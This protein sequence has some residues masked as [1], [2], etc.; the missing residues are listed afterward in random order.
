LKFAAEPHARRGP[1]SSLLAASTFGLLTL[2][3]AALTFATDIEGVLPGALDQPQVNA[4][5]RRSPT[6][7]PL[8]TGST[9]DAADF[10]VGAFLDTGA[11]GHLLSNETAGYH[12][13]N[14]PSNDVDGLGVQRDASV[15]GQRT[16]F[17]DVGGGGTVQFN[18]SEPLYMQLASY[19]QNTVYGDPN[20]PP[21]TFRPQLSDFG[22]VSG[23]VR[24]QVGPVVRPADFDPLQNLDVIG[25]PAMLGKVTVM[26]N[27]GLN[28]F[29]TTQD[30][31]HDT[32]VLDT[33]IYNPGTPFNPVDAAV[34]QASVNPGIPG[35]NRHIGL[36]YANFN[37]FSTVTPTGAP[38]PT[39]AHNPFV[40]KDP[41]RLADGTSQPD[42]PGIKMSF[43]GATAEGNFLLDTGAGASFI[44]KG[45]AASLGIH[46][47]AGHEPGDPQSDPPADPI[48]VD[49][50]NNPIPNQFTIDI[51]AFGADDPN[52]PND[53]SAIRIAGFYL[54]NML[55][56]TKEGSAANDA[57][58]RHFNYRGAP[59]LVNDITVSRDLGGGNL[60]TIT[61]DGVFGMNFLA[62]SAEPITS[63]FDPFVTAP[64]AF[65][66]ITF[67]EPNA[68][69]GIS[70]GKPGD[71]D[72]DGDVDG[73]DVGIWASNFTGSGG[74]T[75]KTW[76]QGD[77]DY[78][79]DVDGNDVGLWATNFT[80]SGG[81]ILSLPDADP[82]AVAALEA[83]GF[84]VVPEPT[85]LALLAFG[86]LALGRRRRQAPRA[87]LSRLNVV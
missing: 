41:V 61:L 8:T 56:R 70:M 50:N 69:L 2:A 18:V 12:D 29:A 83:M 20:D 74:S 63:I 1:S 62:A 55:V 17:E 9:T 84:T 81:R 22:P 31:E 6:G 40:G 78:D 52:D 38:G 7:D 11:S 4:L 30:V 51:S 15:G 53:S 16:V 25:M 49:A 26:D 36:S 76:D 64:G 72:L 80:G 21:G 14:D 32:D 66:W 35:T 86:G 33:Y 24:T 45:K 19:N 67:D 5:F 82:G 27:R 85:G 43:N 46:Y 39:L 79:G 10:T 71:A 37:A 60:Q 59:V 77:W 57:D 28:K 3:P 42:V 47:Q 54:D 48:L 23:P 13:P 87:S 58:P 73:N 34:P 68:T 65:D 44:S 75:T